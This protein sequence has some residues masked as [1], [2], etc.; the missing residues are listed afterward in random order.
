MKYYFLSSALFIVSSLFCMEREIS[1]DMVL[2]QLFD[3]T[4]PYKI[5]AWKLKNESNLFRGYYHQDQ[6][7]I[8][9]DGISTKAMQLYDKA[10]DAHIDNTKKENTFSQFFNNLSHDEQVMLTVVAGKWGTDGAKQLYAPRLIAQLWPQWIKD[11]NKDRHVEKY[12]MKLCP[13]YNPLFNAVQHYMI[14]ANVRNKQVT[15]EKAYSFESEIDDGTALVKKFSNGCFKFMPK[16]TGLNSNLCNGT[17]YQSGFIHEKELYILY[18]HAMAPTK[19]VYALTSSKI[20]DDR[21]PNKSEVNIWTLDPSVFVKKITHIEDIKDAIFS[22][23][24]QWVATSSRGPDG[25]LV[26]THLGNT[27]DDPYLSETELLSANNQALALCFNNSSTVLAVDMQG[28]VSLFTLRSKGG[29]TIYNTFRFYPHML[30]LQFNS[31]DTRLICCA[32]HRDMD[33]DR[34]LVIIWDTSGIANFKELSRKKFITDHTDGAN[35]YFKHDAKNIAAVATD[36]TVMFFDVKSVKFLSKTAELSKGI[37]SYTHKGLVFMP[38][39]SVVCVGMDTPDEESSCVNLYDYISGDCIGVIPYEQSNMYGIGVTNNF[40]YLVTTF[41]GYTAIKTELINDKQQA[42]F[43]KIV[44]KLT[45]LDFYALL[46]LHKEYQQKCS[47]GLFLS[48]SLLRY[49][50]DSFFDSADAGQDLIRQYF[51]PSSLQ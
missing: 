6:Q 25:K 40:R 4:V 33:K 49:I 17:R 29:T 43:S 19:T 28:G 50:N 36:S 47:A 1:H 27:Q 39:S 30:A 41:A 10:L 45:L 24:G 16:I 18:A 11:N 46:E 35:I 34:C 15:Q 13:E 5:A 51:L 42:A 37:E 22:P 23:D 31:D 7:P 26:L 2:V 32:S 38:C 12:T 3:E 20:Q 44:K 8:T 21:F 9:I 14:A 48:S